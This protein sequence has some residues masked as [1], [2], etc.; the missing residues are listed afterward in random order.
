MI[1]EREKKRKPPV[2]RRF[3][4]QAQHHLHKTAIVIV[5]KSTRGSE[6]ARDRDKEEGKRC[7][8]GASFVCNSQMLRQ[9][10]RRLRWAHRSKVVRLQD[11][12]GRSYR[13]ETNTLLRRSTTHYKLHFFSILPLCLGIVQYWVLSN[14]EV[15][16]YSTCLT[17]DQLAI[18]TANSCL[19]DVD[20]L[21]D[22]SE[23]IL[24]YWL[25]YS[26]LLYPSLPSPVPN[27][28]AVRV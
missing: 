18:H 15:Q 3:L 26:I 14:S 4:L 12:K 21:H 9:S 22:S 24:Q 11:R 2:R 7:L 10:S 1:R 5:V 13:Q 19:N 16:Q 27:S 28:A 17:L 23:I 25:L 8:H 6:E 20:F